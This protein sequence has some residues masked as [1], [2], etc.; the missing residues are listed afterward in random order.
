MISSALAGSNRGMRVSVPPPAIVAFI[1]HVWPNEWNSGSAPR[2]VSSAPRSYR[3]REIST[4]RIRFAC[5][6]S[7]PFGVPVVPEV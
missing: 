7:A 3:L 5:V 1:A 4:L 6:S 2:I